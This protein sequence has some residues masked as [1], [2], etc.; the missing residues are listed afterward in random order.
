MFPTKTITSMENSI[1][2][3]SLV[4]Y[5]LTKHYKASTHK[6]K[7]RKVHNNLFDVRE[8]I[9]I[10]CISYSSLRQDEN[11]SLTTQAKGLLL[12]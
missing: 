6:T 8:K 10:K 7:D 1:S 3:Y 9:S 12:L 5:H 4:C 2:L 11:K